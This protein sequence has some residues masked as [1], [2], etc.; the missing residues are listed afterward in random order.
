M[1]K[2]LFILAIFVTLSS[3][4]FAQQASE[5]KFMQITTVESV[6]VAALAVLK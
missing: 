5:S 1:K 3:G 2:S 4:V 6:V